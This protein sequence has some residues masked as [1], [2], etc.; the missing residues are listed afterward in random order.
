MT[1][2]PVLIAGEWR[3]SHEAKAFFQ[4]TNPATR[5]SLPEQF[6]ISDAEDIRLA[7]EAASEAVLALRSIPPEKIA[8]FLER[9]AKNIEDRADILVEVANLETALPKETRLRV[10]E[11]PRTTNQLR[12]AAAAARE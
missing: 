9:Y 3:Q 5:V 1:F 8:D 10:T 2:Q 4:A 12:Q 11:L 6:P 7:L